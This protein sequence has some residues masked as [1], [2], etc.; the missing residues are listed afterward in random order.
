MIG[1]ARRLRAA[2]LAV[3]GASAVLAAAGPL[4]LVPFV[5]VARAAA[6]D[7][8][9]AVAFV[10][11]FGG[12]TGP[13]VG[14]VTVPSGTNGYQAL[15]DFTAQQHEQAPT[16][17]ASGLLCSIN[18]IPSSGC[19]QAVGGG[20]IY[21]SYWRGTTGSWQYA[22][23]GA[24]AAVQPGDVEGWRFENPGNA[25]PS[26]PPP[27]ASP[28]YAAICGAATAATTTSVPAGQAGGAGPSA[29]PSSAAPG[30]A[31]SSPSPAGSAGATSPAGTAPP[32]DHGASAT[33]TTPSTAAGG[34]AGTGTSTTRP[35]PGGPAQSLRA[36]D[37]ATTRPAGTGVVPVAVGAGLVALLAGLALWRWRR[38]P[39]MP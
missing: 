32:A 16:Y 2:V 13:V 19:G 38:R 25:N 29:G 27:G 37:A 28:G 15:A 21:W 30:G 7:T 20:Y 8:T 6:A 22:D 4:A 33:S 31:G 34:R 26:D 36:A 1:R 12:G 39:R 14:C 10:V 17:N 9:V 18:G 35:V 5:D 23:T 11:D 3:G 24:F